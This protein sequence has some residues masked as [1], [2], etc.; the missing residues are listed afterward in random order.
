[1]Q[2]SFLDDPILPIKAPALRLRKVKE[3]QIA[4][5]FKQIGNQ[6]RFGVILQRFRFDFPLAICQELD[7]QAWWIV[8]STQGDEVSAFCIRN[9]LKLV[10]ES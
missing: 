6:Q 5:R 1:M 8:A 7:G 4:V 2:L 3:D 10:E 9:G